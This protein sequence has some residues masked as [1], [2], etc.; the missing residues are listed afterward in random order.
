MGSSCLRRAGFERLSR[1]LPRPS[2]AIRPIGLPGARDSHGFP[3]PKAEHQLLQADCG[4]VIGQYV[5]GGRA[6]QRG[7]TR[8]RIAAHSPLTAAKAHRCSTIP[9][10]SNSSVDWRQNLGGSLP[11]TWLAEEHL[12]GIVRQASKRPKLKRRMIDFSRPCRPRRALPAGLAGS[13][14]GHHHLAAGTES[15]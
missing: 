13:I 15:T 8:Y 4:S 9:G 7:S 14:R 1:V 11:K 10:N 12:V 2:G 6:V 5:F 3:L